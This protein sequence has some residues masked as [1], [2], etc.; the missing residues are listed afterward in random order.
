VFG[1]SGAIRDAH[2]NVWTI[3]SNTAIEVNGVVD[4]TSGN[5]VELAYVGGLIWQTVCIFFIAII[6]NL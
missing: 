4:A 2:G 3:N 6:S 5:V 1:T